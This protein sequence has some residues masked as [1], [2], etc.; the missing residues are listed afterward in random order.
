MEI[1]IPQD[2]PGVGIRP[3]GQDDRQQVEH[4]W[5]QQFVGKLS[6]IMGGTLEG[7]PPRF[8]YMNDIGFQNGRITH[9]LCHYHILGFGDI[10]LV[11]C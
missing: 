2:H 9:E 8:L 5:V 1:E 3:F 7:I 10:V 4:F 6:W 11:K